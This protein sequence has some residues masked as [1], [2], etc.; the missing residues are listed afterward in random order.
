[1]A[2]LVCQVTAKSNPEEIAIRWCD[3]PACFEEYFLRD[4]FLTR[5]DKYVA[6]SREKLYRVSYHYAKKQYDN[7]PKASYE[8]ASAGHKLY[9][10]LFDSNGG[11]DPSEV[12][13]WLEESRDL[14]LV[15]SLEIVVD[16][17]RTGPQAVPWNLLYDCEPDET[18]FLTDVYVEQKASAFSI[19]D[20]RGEHWKPFWGIRYNL[21]TG[22]RVDPLRRMPL[23]KEPLHVVV[24]VNEGV[25]PENAS[26][27]L[28]A[29][30]T[31]AKP[32]CCR[33][34][35]ILKNTSDLDTYCGEYPVDL[36]YWFCET[37]DSLALRLPYVT[38]PAGQKREKSF[39]PH[40][41]NEICRKHF[42]RRSRG[43]AFLNA[44]RTAEE[45]PDGSFIQTLD[46]ARLS[47]VVATEHATPNFFA[48]DFGL[49]FLAA[50]LEKGEEVGKALQW[51]R[52]HRAPLGLLYGTYCPPAI[53]VLR[54]APTANDG[55]TPGGADQPPTGAETGIRAEAPSETNPRVDAAPAG[56]DQPSSGPEIRTL[57]DV[58]PDTKSESASAPAANASR[59]GTTERLLGAED[60]APE[61]SDL[62][63]H[64]YRSLE[65]YRREHRFLLAGRD[66]DVERFGLLLDEPDS[67]IVVLHGETGV[68][69]SSFLQAGLI[70]FLEEECIAYRFIRDRHGKD[71]HP[72]LLIHATG[73]P[74]GELA[75]ALCDYC[76]RPEHYRTPNKKRG[77]VPVDLPGILRGILGEQPNRAVLRTKLW[78]NPRLLSDLLIALADQLP[79]I[80][81]LVIDQ[82]EEVFTLANEENRRRVL[83]MLRGVIA[84]QGKF[85]IILS[86]RTEYYGRLIHQLRRNVH[87]FRGVRDYF[88]ADL[89]KAQLSEAI[90]RP[91]AYYGFDYEPGLAEEIAHQAIGYCADK[92]DSVLPLVQIICTE[93]YEVGSQHSD[94][95]IRPQ[96]FEHI[97]KLEGGLRKHVERML[98]Q[99][100]PD[101]VDKKV[102]QKVFSKLCQHNPDGT[103]TAAPMR[104]TRFRDE[105]EK[106][107]RM[108]FD[109][110]VKATT[111]ADRCLL[112][113]KAPSHEESNTRSISLGHDALA[114]IAHAWGEELARASRVRK[115][116]R[117]LVSVA[118]VALLMTGLAAVAAV[119]WRDAEDQKAM[120]EATLYV[121]RIG[122]AEREGA[123]SN[124]GRAEELLNECPDYLRGWEWRYLKG[125]GYAEPLRLREHTNRVYCVAFGRDGPDGLPVASGGTDNMVIVRDARTGK[126]I[127]SFDQHKDRV[128]SV[129]FSPNGQYLASASWDTT[130]RIWDWRNGKEVDFSPLTGHDDAV[131]SLAFSPNGKLLATGSRDKTI[132]VW[133]ATTGKRVVWNAGSNKEICALAGH[134]LMVTSVA[135]SPDSILLASA[136]ED[137]TVQFWNVVTGRR[138][139][140]EPRVGHKEGVTGV[141]FDP[142]D[143]NRLASTSRD[144]TVRFWDVKTGKE[145]RILKGIDRVIFGLAFSPDGRRLVTANLDKS[146]TFWNTDNGQEILTLRGHSNIVY[147]VAFSRDRNGEW[148]ASASWDKTV[149]IWHAPPIAQTSSQES[150]SLTEHEG[151]VTAVAFSPDGRFLAS[152]GK[153]EKVRVW[154]VVSGQAPTAPPRTLKGH[155]AT[156]IGLAFHPTKPLVA[157]CSF[158]TK[159]RVWE[160]DTVKEA[161]AVLEA[162]Q[163]GF[164]FGV[165]FSPDGTRIATCG[166]DGMVKLWSASNGNWNL[167][168]TKEHIPLEDPCLVGRSHS[169]QVIRVAFSPDGQYLASVGYD[170]T[171][172]VWNV[173]TPGLV[174]TLRGHTDIVW[175]VAFSPDGRRLASASWD[176]TVKIWDWAQQRE[177]STLPAPQESGELQ[178][179]R[180]RWACFE[181]PQQAPELYGHKDRVFGVAFSPDGRYLASASADQT[182][183]LWDVDTC[184]EKGT[185]RGHLG[186]VWSV[187]FSPDGKRVA[188]ASFDRTVKVWNIVELLQKPGP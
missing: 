43:L 83:E 67:R 70:P 91:C 69:K 68:G 136:S 178:A 30:E 34:L 150:F 90:V 1:M 120:L 153:D 161:I 143:G 162:S 92:Q 2:H 167:G 40:D 44:C 133:D 148:L 84:S 88:L 141:A 98:A 79:H 174:R 114:P 81:V 59:N 158:D 37:N 101:P 61:S 110:M 87:R 144:G 171:V 160:A 41:L 75:K 54:P 187:A 129:A 142:Q 96:D 7:M 117:G 86:L 99:L 121:N 13:G 139:H 20:A 97:G 135:F 149:K 145:T 39:G 5:F 172:K 163:T 113:W 185:L 63:P 182:V 95:V 46:E 77:L 18:A 66:A 159:V 147:G 17:R 51:L 64:P 155:K 50:F 56:A 184:K 137:K 118:A 27:R 76:S 107:G 183:K 15:E 49:A 35:K 80:L 104:L 82:F 127:V 22:R 21:A 173:V 119:K 116:V 102:F 126:K 165:A 29:L 11:Q 73:D 65:S 164:V 94:K 6:E 60:R 175:D 154:D 108:R 58:A 55:E 23:W 38:E 16:G 33:I 140:D 85:K 47:G 115:L 9:E 48:N 14:D 78:E 134:Q 32:Q 166:A 130:V 45:G 146:M 26:Q 12:R 31:S 62:P 125:L 105:W 131:T 177:V 128:L 10:A 53:R 74:V 19:D 3:G 181:F 4:G 72:I 109:D 93:L 138:V 180:K 106:N 124:L 176:G 151:G 57:A 168:I 132:M 169:D 100:L 24:V 25:L 36:M 188:S 156:V 28:K 89:D 186:Y 122:L 123:A 112:K 170:L 157:S 103:V 42:R 8:L 52:A 152:G 111:R 179:F 71:A